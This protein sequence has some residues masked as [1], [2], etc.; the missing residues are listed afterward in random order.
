M[1]KPTHVIYGGL[2][3][4]GLLAAGTTAQAADQSS[5]EKGVE[6][7]DGY[8]YSEA[9][10]YFQRAAEQGNR[11]A[12]RNLALMRLYGDL[13]YGREISRN[14]KEA[15]RWLQQAAADGCEVS[16]FMLKV[17]AQHGR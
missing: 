7:V 6:A 11:N 5:Y 1:R 9:L 14:Q 8:R 10:M 15:K 4:L 12:E 17:L 13:L 3:A 2:L 16:A